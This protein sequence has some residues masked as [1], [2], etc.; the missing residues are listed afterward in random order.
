[1]WDGRAVRPFFKEMII[2]KKHIAII[3]SAVS[4]VGC[5]SQASES[6][7]NTSEKNES[8][9][10]SYIVFSAD[11]NAESAEIDD[12]SD[13]LSD[14]LTFAYPHLKYESS[15]DY[16]KNTIRLEF[17]MD[18]LWHKNTAEI[19]TKPNYLEIHKGTSQ[20]DELVLSN[21][22][23]HYAGNSFVSTNNDYSIIIYFDNEGIKKFSDVT[24]EI[25]GTDTPISIWIDDNHIVSPLIS[26]PIYNGQ[27]TINGGFDCDSAQE[28][29]L[30]ITPYPLTYNISVAEESYGDILPIT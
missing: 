15:V 23:I 27:V 29:A 24:T 20:D 25:A 5:N 7:E 19:L 16:E 30:H 17:N 21:E 6:S 9:F 28:I 13:I 26:E 11:V 12:I 8:Q 14:R 10:N 1:M 18:E 3:L 4:L 2:K 22:D